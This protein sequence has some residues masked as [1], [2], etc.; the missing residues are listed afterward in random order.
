M[1]RHGQATLFLSRYEREEREDES[2]R[3]SHSQ[4]KGVAVNGRR[5]ASI[6]TCRRKRSHHHLVV[7]PLH[8][9]HCSPYSQNAGT[10]RASH[11][12][13]F[14]TV[15]HLPLPVSFLEPWIPSRLLAGPAALT[16]KTLRSSS[17]DLRQPLFALLDFGLF[18]LGTLL[19]ILSHRI[20]MVGFQSL[21]I[22]LLL[23]SW[24]TAHPVPIN[25]PLYRWKSE[26]CKL[27]PRLAKILCPRDTP[28]G[29]VSVSTPIG[30]AEGTSDDAATRFAVKYASASRFEPPT[31]ATQWELP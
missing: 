22:P 29:S 18:Q 4:N 27:S 10:A 15:I 11:A 12:L 1:A 25:F 30:T 6:P 20:D 7:G 14:L 31:L 28:T 13:L 8:G 9:R 17:R 19:P 24:A 2:T 23:A 16:Y 21:V 5:S 26:L 3:T